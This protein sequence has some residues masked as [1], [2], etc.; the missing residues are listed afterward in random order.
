MTNP[1][2]VMSF[3]EAR[4]T[5]TH[6]RMSEEHG[7]ALTRDQ[8]FS[9]NTISTTPR[10][11]VGIPL[12]WLMLSIALLAQITVSIMTQGVPILAPFIQADLG[13]T[14]GQVGLFNS[15][16]MSG[17][18]LSMFTAGWVVDV[19]GERA[20]LMW[21]NLIVGAFCFTVAGTHGFLTALLAL[22]A[23]GMGASFP[24]PAGSKAV[25]SWFP[26]AKRGVAMGVR[27]TGI[28]VGGALAA[29]TLPA[30]AATTGWRMAVVVS[31]MV[32]FLSVI[33]CWFTYRSPDEAMAEATPGK[34]KT[35]E[36]LSD[37]LT[38]DVALLGLAGALLPLGQ[39][40]LLT[41][42]ALYLKE[43]QNIPFTT[44][45][46]LLVGAQVAGASGRILWGLWS[47]R[48]FR[49]HRKPALVWASLFSTGG[50]LLLGWLPPGV[51]LWLI[52][53]AVLFYAFN[54]IGWHGSWIAMLAEIAGPNKQ[55]RTLGLAMT[56]M[57]PGI[58]ALPPLF[59]LLVDYTHSWRLAWSVAA[60]VLAIG[61]AMI[62]PVQEQ[63]NHS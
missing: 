6:H 3:R 22:F 38:R 53:L 14:R 60:A 58:I 2:F 7:K 50:S 17:S 45:A 51:P 57:Y 43:T 62:L 37:I 31:G 39:F 9:S 13:L 56:I 11:R 8:I 29:A 12:H 32:C 34:R 44:T 61:T 26:V 59:G 4:K 54:T 35:R 28:P 21:G 41:Y 1:F 5:Y 18:L 23:A 49:Q 47:D 40:A 36:R 25:M 52:G 48:W 24:T 19:K 33:V 46:T 30:I 63:K 55:G 42:L 15:A 10:T 27:Q 20:A 16:I